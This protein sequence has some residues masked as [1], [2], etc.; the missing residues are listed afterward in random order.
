MSLQLINMDG[1]LGIISDSIGEQSITEGI[2]DLQT[3][4]GV[5]QTNVDELQTNVGVLQTDVEELQSS[6]S[7]FKQMFNLTGQ[8]GGQYYLNMESGT[9]YLTKDE[10]FVYYPTIQSNGAFRLHL[11]GFAGR[12]KDG[13]IVE[14][15]APNS[16][17]LWVTGNQNSVPITVYQSSTAETTSHRFYGTVDSSDATL[18]NWIKLS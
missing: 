4:V 2:S 14:V 8:S 7:S 5:L 15:Y 12:F 16:P 18:F 9:T 6:L 10:I 1:Q 13:V 3:N 17:G 11:P